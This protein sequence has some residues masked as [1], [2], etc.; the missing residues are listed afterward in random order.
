MGYVQRFGFGLFEARRALAANGN[1]P[2]N[3]QVE[4]NNILATI[5]AAL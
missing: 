4:P 5:K 2:L 1:P 3:F